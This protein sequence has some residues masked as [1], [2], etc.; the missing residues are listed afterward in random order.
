M[1]EEPGEGQ[2][3]AS[4]LKRRFGTNP[5]LQ[6]AAAAFLAGTLACGLAPNI[7][8]LLAGRVLQGAGEGA[9][10]G[11]IYMLIP[12]VFPPLLIPAIFGVEAVIWAAGSTM[13]PILDGFLTRH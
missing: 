12:E 10:S 4:P 5:A 11:L 6:G 13:G 9:I 7:W 8:L 1:A 2:P 3:T